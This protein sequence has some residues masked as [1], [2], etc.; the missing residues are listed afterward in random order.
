MLGI[1]NQ[2]GTEG[3]IGSRMAEGWGPCGGAIR[4]REVLITSQNHQSLVVI[5]NRDSIFDPHIASSATT[6]LTLLTPC[7]HLLQRTTR[8]RSRSRSR[9][10]IRRSSRSRSPRRDMDT[11]QDAPSTAGRT[12]DHRRRDDRPFD[13]ARKAMGRE[14]AASEAAKRSKK[15]CRVYVGNLAFGVKWND[16]KDFM[17]EGA[18]DF[19]LGSSGS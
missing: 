9:S 19:Y 14:I 8:R 12:V 4:A 17:R 18:L 15:D 6:Q 5:T 3:V 2:P 11:D 10:P 16:L 1:G 13:P 7:L